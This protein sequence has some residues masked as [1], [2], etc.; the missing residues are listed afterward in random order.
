MAHCASFLTGR[1][2]LSH[3]Q[4]CDPQVIESV[5]ARRSSAGQQKALTRESHEQQAALLSSLA[6]GRSYN[7]RPRSLHWE[8]RR[9]RAGGVDGGHDG[10]VDSGLEIRLKMSFSG[11]IVWARVA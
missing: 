1:S 8:D 10:S 3:A 4:R 9:G 11:L 6:D 2:L 5:V 7:L